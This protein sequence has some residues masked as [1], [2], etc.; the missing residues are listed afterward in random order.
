MRLGLLIILT[1]LVAC[2][3]P[4]APQTLPATSTLGTYGTNR[5]VRITTH[6]H[7]PY[8]F[9][10]C[11]GAGTANAAPGGALNTIC[12]GHLRTALC[13]NR[14]DIAFT[15][16]HPANF[17]NYAIKDLVLN[18]SGDTLVNGSNGPYYNKLGDCD[19]GSFTPIVSAGFE[20]NM[21][22]I[23][24]NQQLNG[25]T[26]PTT[27]TGLVN[28]NDAATAAL[29]RSS[30][31]GVV[32]IP[33]TEN[34]ALSTLQTIAPDAIEV[35]NLHA[36]LDPK[37][38]KANLGVPPYLS[39]GNMVNYVLDPYA[40]L[41]PDFAF[42][43]F[44]QQFSNYTLMWDQLISGG[45]KVTG[46]AAVDSHEN[47]LNLPLADGERFDSY[48]RT[49]KIAS[50]WVAAPSVDIDQVKTGIT[51]GKVLMVY[52]GF[53]TPMGFDFSATLGG[54]TVRMGSDGASQLTLGGGTATIQV[55]LP[56][57]NTSLV[58]GVTAP[59]IRI[60]LKQVSG[61]SDVI[62]AQS[63][64]A[65]LSAPVTIAGAY[66]AEV[67]ITPYHLREY[68]GSF[69]SYAESE[70]LWIATNHIYIN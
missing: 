41:V 24:L 15:S 59:K 52:E 18:Q 40:D 26:D 6:F 1:A 68:L 57:I 16:D 8:S 38:R 66:R 69:K 10:A 5:W 37:I 61:S 12:L 19:G 30:S 48:R 46:V 60:V 29:I 49:S 27:L 4:Q 64:G 33:H 65:S 63:T 51:N 3:R 32:I 39:I 55:S 36:N 53:G 34:K 7:T 43:T 47:V 2:S 17:V 14:I 22:G 54:T 56:T 9:D 35:Y 62:V 28:G 42:V 31:A 20:S 67:Y 45:L 13:R 50:N 23:G 44:I 70:F 11:D 21:S 58:Q 25:S